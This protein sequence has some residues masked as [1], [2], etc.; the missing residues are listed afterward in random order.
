MTP[1]RLSGAG[2][3]FLIE[4]L[5]DG[6]TAPSEAQIQNL[7]RQHRVDGY[8][9]LM[10]QRHEKF[11]WNFFNKDGSSAEFCGNAA[12]CAQ[13]YL[14]EVLQKD[15]A[16]H[17]TISGEIETFFHSDSHWVQMPKAEI[18]QQEFTLTVRGKD[19]SGLWCDTGVPH[20]V[21]IN[22]SGLLDRTLSKELRF[23]PDLGNRG[24]N[25]TWVQ[26]NEGEYLEATTY[27]RGV[28]DFTQAC[29]TGAL[30]AALWAHQQQ[31]DKNQFRIKMP[32]GLLLVKRIR[33]H[34]RMTGPV[35]K[36][37]EWQG[38]GT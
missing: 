16:I 29:G 10:S 34:W 9:G 36:L 7:C 27:E 31:A 2:N 11:Q 28:E 17:K 20:F 3:T 5:T 26:R 38:S 15:R 12:R 37:G 35:T 23:H 33:S 13:Y 19:Y 4:I 30:A 32:G 8:L 1:W 6:K 22:E 18:F 14:Y 21:V 25:I 24:A